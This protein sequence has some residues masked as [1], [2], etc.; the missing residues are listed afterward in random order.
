MKIYLFSFCEHEGDEKMFEK[1]KKVIPEEFEKRN[2]EFVQY[3]GDINEFLNIYK[4]MEY[5]ICERFHSLILSYVC[6]QKNYVLSYSEKINNV[7]EELKLCNSYLNLKDIEKEDKINLKDFTDVDEKKLKILKDEAEKQ[8][9]AVDR[10]L[11]N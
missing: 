7:I 8:F 6:K 5:M 11:K 4:Q 1:I 10:F 3:K 9:E 2:V